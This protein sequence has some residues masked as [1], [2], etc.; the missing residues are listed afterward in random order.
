LGCGICH[1]S[2]TPD[3]SLV[4]D[5]NLVSVLVVECIFAHLMLAGADNC[6]LLLDH[7]DMCIENMFVDALDFL[8]LWNV[9]DYHLLS[10]NSGGVL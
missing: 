10:D 6:N 3:D 8:L 2:S 7:S 9:G 5:H 4:D 1:I